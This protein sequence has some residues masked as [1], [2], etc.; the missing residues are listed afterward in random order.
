MTELELFIYEANDMQYDEV[1]SQL[2][3]EQRIA[4]WTM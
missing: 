4:M 2:E 1:I 3:L